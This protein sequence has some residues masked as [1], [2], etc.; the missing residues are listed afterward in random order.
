MNNIYS[1]LK[2]VYFKKNNSNV[3]S[4]TLIFAFALVLI[5]IPLPVIFGSISSM[6]FI[7]LFL[8]LER[9]KMFNSSF[10]LFLPISLFFL[11]MISLLWSIDFA[12][13]KNSFQKEILLLLFPIVFLFYKKYNKQQLYKSIEIYSF[14]MVVFAVFKLVLAVYNYMQTKNINVFFYHELVSL[15]LNAIYVATFS[16][17]ALFYFLQLSKKNN[18]HQFCIAILT[19]FV[20]LLSSKSIIFID[21]ILIV[22]FYARFAIIPKSVKFFTIS[23]VLI[24]VFSSLFFV[25]QI[26]NRFLIEY[27][28]AFVDNTVNTNSPNAT[29]YNVSI[30]QAWNNEVFYAYNYFPGG[31]LRV[32]QFRIF[33]EMVASDQVFFY[34]Y[35]H[36]AAQSKIKEK[37]VQ[38]HLY[39]GYGDFNFHNQYVQTFAELGFFGFLILIMMVFINIRNAF[40]SKDFL[41]I[42]FAVTTLFLFLTES[43]LCRQRG[44]VYFI[45]LYCIFNTSNQ[46]KLQNSTS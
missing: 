35:G 10:A 36:N 39:K 7:L 29:V 32:Y 37:E 8:F 20:F 28:T 23:A 42:V 3:V 40:K 30:N 9:K 1:F 27:Q 11:M 4:Q 38:H 6:L 15:D 33:C 21:V 24:F 26:R 18:L 12:E 34:G 43:M 41:H 44:I 5:C 31:A 16:S 13:T 22:Y 14:F 2:N 25:K 17:F 45:T 46:P 19:L